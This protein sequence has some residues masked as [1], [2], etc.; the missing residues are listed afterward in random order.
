MPAHRK[1]H[2]GPALIYSHSPARPSSPYPYPYDVSLSRSL[3]YL[4]AVCTPAFLKNFSTH[5]S[6]CSQC[7]SGSNAYPAITR[8]SQESWNGGCPR[9]VVLVKPVSAPS[10][11]DAAPLADQIEQREIRDRA[12]VGD[13]VSFS[14]NATL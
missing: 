11:G 10:G 9:S 3:H 1:P 12:P 13:A 4:L 7:L 2:P 6:Q 5:S 8:Q 14:P